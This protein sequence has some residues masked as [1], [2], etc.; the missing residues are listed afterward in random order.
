MAKTK[1][2]PNLPHPV[3]IYIKYQFIYVKKVNL[4]NTSPSGTY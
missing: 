1:R 3:C 2:A 4:N